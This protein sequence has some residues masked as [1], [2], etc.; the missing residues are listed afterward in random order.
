MQLLHRHGSFAFAITSSY[1]MIAGLAGSIFAR[2]RATRSSS[3]RFIWTTISKGF[4]PTA[5]PRSR[6]RST[7][8]NWPRWFTCAAQVRP[9]LSRSAGSDSS[10]ASA[11]ANTTSQPT[12]PA[13]KR[14]NASSYPLPQVHKA[15]RLGAL[16]VSGADARQSR[17]CRTKIR[18]APRGVSLI[19]SRTQMRTASAQ[20]RSISPPTSRR[21]RLARRV[22]PR[23][24][25]PL[26]PGVWR[27]ASRRAVRCGQPACAG[28]WRRRY[29][30]GERL[31][32]LR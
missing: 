29:G 6:V 26:P 12:S 20:R 10:R 19:H 23:R 17:G 14:W 21:W 27:R 28:Q 22:R 16:S 15:A 7:N 4:L 32:M 24:V 2:Y 31:C 25:H 13:S 18:T 9:R 11:A 5:Q 8:G 30:S 3:R 1:K